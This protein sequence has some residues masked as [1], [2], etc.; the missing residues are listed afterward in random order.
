MT[1][2]LKAKTVI[3]RNPQGTRPDPVPFVPPFTRTNLD[4]TSHVVLRT[5]IH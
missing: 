4:R 3:H 2:L 5:W 1:W